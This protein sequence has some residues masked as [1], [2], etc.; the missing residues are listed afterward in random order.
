[1]DTVT[2]SLSAHP[3][4]QLEFL[5]NSVRAYLYSVAFVLIGSLLVV[6]L[7]RVILSRV[8]RLAARTDSGFDDFLILS[9]KRFGIPSL[10]AAVL[11]LGVRDL[12]MR[13]AVEKA[14]QLGVY[15]WIAL[16]VVRFV[17]GL[18]R[19][20]LE[21]HMES[22]A[23]SPATA[24]QEKKSVRGIIVFVNIIL[25]A[26]AFVLVMDNLGLKVTTFVAG[27]GIGG[28]AIALA[29][30]AV[31]GD[32][33]SYFVI[34]FDR[35][36]QVGH[37]IK[38][39]DFMGEVENIG[40]KTTRLRSLTGETIV[41]S[42]KYLTD[43]QVQNY[44]LMTR[45]RLAYVFYVEYGSTSAQLRAVPEVAKALVQRHERATFDRCHFKEFA[46]SGLRF[47][48]VYFIEVPEL[49]TALDIQQEVNIGLK[50][51][52]EARGLGFAFPTRTLLMVPPATPDA[53]GGATPDAKSAG[54]G[55]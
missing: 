1:M 51:E 37:F 20:T 53:T 13:E 10:H 5:N 26:L 12:V 39:G 29:A 15:L 19:A 34:F 32:L 7:N 24:E 25:W 55:A 40:I 31:L 38:I 27:L 23:T 17:S 14:L 50:E 49:A 52:L 2:T 11:Y 18:I 6:L 28:I 21:R 9:I 30:Q 54:G 16:N 4:L 43:N 35:P 44:R 42:N 8:Q 36:F 3:W 22:R 47:E 48:L 41:M 46:E 45:R 33:F